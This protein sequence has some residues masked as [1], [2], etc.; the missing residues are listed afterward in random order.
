MNKKQKE[1]FGKFY[2][3]LAKLVF[4]GVVLFNI[5]EINNPI[6]FISLLS[7]IISIVLFVFIGNKYLK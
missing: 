5:S 1:E 7:G 6:K 4:A 2:F 3:D